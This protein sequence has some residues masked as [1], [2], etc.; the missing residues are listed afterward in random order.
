[1]LRRLARPAGCRIEPE[2]GESGVRVSFINYGRK[3]GHFR[4]QDLC[5]HLSLKG[6]Q[7]VFEETEGADWY[8]VLSPLSMDLVTRAARLCRQGKRVIFDNYYSY[9]ESGLEEGY[10]APGSVRERALRLVE[11]PMFTLA[12]HVLVDTEASKSFY[13]NLYNVPCERITAL[14]AVCGSSRFMPQPPSEKIR[15]RFALGDVTLVYHGSFLG[16]H[17]VDAMIGAFEKLLADYPSATL[18]LVGDGSRRMSLQSAHSH[19]RIKF[20]GVVP[21]DDAPEYLSAATLWLGA[22]GGTAKAQRTARTGMFDAMALGLTVVTGD[23]EENRRV[24]EDGVN[25]HL[26]APESEERLYTKLKEIL[27]RKLFTGTRA[28]ESLVGRFD[29]PTMGARLEA[30]LAAPDANTAAHRRLP[31]RMRVVLGGIKLGAGLKALR[32]SRG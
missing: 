24:I 27:V 5:S 28:R 4:A 2:Y 23:T 22:F 21:Y 13:V 15:R 9:V 7:V 26:A 11:R 10:F 17:R 12:D 25:G 8:V 31:L 14:Y 29:L 32:G 1:M 30:I 6:F 18:L 19:D 3:A 16:T 20:V